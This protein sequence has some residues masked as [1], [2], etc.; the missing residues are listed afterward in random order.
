MLSLTLP[1][2][3]S[4][5]ILQGLPPSVLLR[6]MRRAHL[7]RFLDVPERLTS[8]GRLGVHCDP[9]CYIDA[10]TRIMF[11][12][13]NVTVGYGS[14]IGA[15][16]LHAWEPITVGRC[17]F[18][19]DGAT[20]LTGSHDV[21]SADFAG[22]RAPINVG[23]YAWIALDAMILPGVTIGEGAVVGARAVVT[24]DVPP[25][26]VVAGNPAQ[27]VRERKQRDFTYVPA[28]WKRDA[29]WQ[30]QIG[31]GHRA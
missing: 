21:D 13:A 20:L 11:E 30:R 6:L 23:D 2:P 8:W 15:C 18:I 12:P 1:S 22:D 7:T 27:S 28:D 31:I 24:K 5:P 9:T 29:A 4:Q 14:N 17:V 26:T 19:S 25:F 16:T 3:V 10:R